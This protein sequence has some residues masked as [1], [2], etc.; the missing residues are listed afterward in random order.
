MKP[1]SVFSVL[2]MTAFLMEMTERWKYPGF[3]LAF[4]ALI[5]LMIATGIN[6]FKFLVFLVITTAYFLVFR[7]PEV[8]NHV[9]LILL[10]N[11][12]LISCMVYAYLRS[13]QYTTGSELKKCY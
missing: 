11:L 12:A 2:Y 10:C 1:F 8:A 3:T 4:L 7:F 6:R 13:R 5:T 9:N